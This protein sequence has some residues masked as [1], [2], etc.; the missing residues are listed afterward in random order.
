MTPMTHMRV[1]KLTTRGEVAITYEGVLAERLADG[2]R[3]EAR[4]ERP[5]LALGYTTFETG[6]RFTEWYFTDRWYNIFEIHAAD[7]A[8]KGWY[9]N[10]AEPAIIGEDVIACRDLLLDLWVAPDGQMLTLDEDEFAAEST[11][12][13]ATRAAARAALGELRALVA[14]RVPPFDALP[15][16]TG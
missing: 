3:L 9:C 4:W 15:P 6:D 14:R 5:A 13:A 7:G 8:L 12:D 11:L 10:V 1:Q 2:V 16:L